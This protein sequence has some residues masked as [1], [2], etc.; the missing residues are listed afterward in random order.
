MN[1]AGKFQQTKA[2]I[3]PTD[4]QAL[5]IQSVSS[6]VTNGFVGT[7]TPYQTD[8]KNGEIYIQGYNVR[9]NKI[10]LK[11][12]T[13]VTPEFAKKQ[14]K[15][16]LQTGDMLTVQSGH[17]GTT[18]VIPPELDGVN[19]HAVIITRF[20]KRI[21]DSRYVAYYLNSSHGKSRT[22]GLEVGSS[23]LHI[24]TKDLKK[25]YIP[26]PPLLEQRKI[27]DI[28]STWDEAIA[29]TEQLTAALQTRKKGLMQRLLTGE[30]RLSEFD[31][32][33]KK[34]NLS[35][36]VKPIARR[37][38]IDTKKKYSLIGVRW[39]VAGAHIHEIVPGD[40]IATKELSR[41]HENDIIYNKMWVT[42]NA[43][44]IARKEHDG[45]YGSTEYP[46]FIP[47][48]NQIDVNFLGFYFHNARFQYDAHR[49]CKGTTGR[50]RL[51]PGDFLEIEVRMP[52]IEEQTE[53]ANLLGTC[54]QEIELQSKKLDAL[55]EQKKGL[56]QRLLTGQVRVKV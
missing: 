30:V 33:W 16:I 20:D 36:L 25:F 10:D 46:Q 56:M 48:P 49:L 12:V 32:E 5:Q 41:I 13:Y 26:L 38:K 54:D 29:K 24:N 45:A 51:N 18:A 50:A 2:G 47:K 55:K 31:D 17:I 9:E 3:L 15:S 1:E 19:C 53:I 11:G 4:W 37:E 6:L 35:E 8:E 44:G 22:R 40:Q 43:F 39:Y 28:L 21:V 34:R 27:A 23:I 7:V 52:K 14:Q 42:K